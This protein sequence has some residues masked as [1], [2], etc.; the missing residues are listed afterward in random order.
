MQNYTFDETL[1]KRQTQIEIQELKSLG[2]KKYF[3]LQSTWNWMERMEKM[4]EK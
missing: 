2:L 1:Q 4:Y 3:F